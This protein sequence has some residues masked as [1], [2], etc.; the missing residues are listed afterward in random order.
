MVAEVSQQPLLALETCEEA[1]VTLE[2]VATFVETS[3]AGM[4][5]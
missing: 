5:L 1:E 4:A 3:V 2:V